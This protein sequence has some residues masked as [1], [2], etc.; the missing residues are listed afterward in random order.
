MKRETMEKGI[1]ID[2]Q[3]VGE[4]DVIMEENQSVSP[5]MSLFWVE[6]KKMHNQKNYKYHPILPF[7]CI[8]V[9]KGI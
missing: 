1:N 7:P 9:L 4:I 8:K 5:F 6:Q 2:K 3:I